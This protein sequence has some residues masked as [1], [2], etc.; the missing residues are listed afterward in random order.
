MS[1]FDENG[2]SLENARE[3]KFLSAEYQALIDLDGSRNERLDASSRS[4]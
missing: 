2:N 1:G 3:E 4:S